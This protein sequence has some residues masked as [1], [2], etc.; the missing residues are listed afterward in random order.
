MKQ[1]K[2]LMALLMATML[3]VVACTAPG[4]SAKESSDTVNV[5]FQNLEAKTTT[6]SSGSVDPILVADVYFQYKAENVSVKDVNGR[7]IGAAT[8]WTD[9]TG[10]GLDKVLKLSRGVWNISLRGFASEEARTAAGTQETVNTKAIFDGKAENV[11]VGNTST[12]LTAE[13]DVELVF[14]NSTGTG[15][16]SVTVSYTAEY[17]AVQNKKAKVTLQSGDSYNESVIL[18]F[19]ENGAESSGVANF[20]NIPNGIATITVDY[21]D[22]ANGDVP[23]EDSGSATTLIMT[24]MHTSASATISM[25]VVKVQVSGTAPEQSAEDIFGSG[26]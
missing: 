9:F 6:V 23:F 13:V 15:S 26:S 3:L 10:K 4:S 21:L 12:A 25:D 14:T 17:A 20:T 22:T 24:D 16:C 19:G 2:K 11:N 18:T 7:V 5:V 1:I 8:D